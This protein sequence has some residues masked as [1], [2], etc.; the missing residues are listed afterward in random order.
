MLAG[1]TLEPGVRSDME[2][3]FRHD[4]SRVRVHVDAGAHETASAYDALAYT[5]GPDIFFR[6]GSYEPQRPDGRRLIAHE[7]AHIVQQS[8]VSN[9][10]DMP[11]RVTAPDDATEVEADRAAA[12]VMHDRQPEVRARLNGGSVT[13]RQTAPAAPRAPAAP[14]PPASMAIANV[15][16]PTPAD[17][18][19]FSWKVNFTLPSASP[20]GGYFIQEVTIRR[21]A[22]GCA[23]A[24]VAGHN[25]AYHYWEAWHVN[26]GGTQDALVA[27]GTYDF[28][29]EFSLDSAGTATKGIFAFTG[30]VR[31]Y[32]GSALPASFVAN[33][34]ATIAGDLPSTTRDPGLAGGT[35]ALTHDIAGSWSCCPTAPRPTTFIGH[36]P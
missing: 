6:R 17:C 24:A 5:R 33:N 9:R 22:L 31:F 21:A 34:P 29:D 2:G 28:A 16:G 8:S 3:R 18:S 15:R 30:S 35:P 36:A 11:P 1:R 4:F 14:T 26:A 25:V 20:A 27:N 12:A 19:A 32:E 23:G 7:L 10:T 13:Q